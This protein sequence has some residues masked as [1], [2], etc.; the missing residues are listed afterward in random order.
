MLALQNNESAELA[1]PELA[2]T[3]VEQQNDRAAKYDL[4]LNVLEKA[5]TL[6]FEWEYSLSLIHI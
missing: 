3:A 5:Q 4:T 6:H 1:L 2:L